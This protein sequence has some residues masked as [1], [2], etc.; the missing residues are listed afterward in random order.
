[1]TST[2]LAGEEDIAADWVVDSDGNLRFEYGDFEAG[3]GFADYSGTS[4]AAPHVTG[5]LGLLF[6]RFP[7]LTGAQ[8]RDVMLT[9]AR[10][11]GEEGVDEIYGWGLL[12]LAAAIE[13]PRQLRVDTV[14]EM[15]LAAG[16]HRTW[17]GDAWDDWTNDIGGPGRLVKSGAGWLRLSG[18]NSFAGATVDQGIL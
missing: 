3:Y 15:N 16:G 2:V 1:I 17:E 8:V 4:M 6:E 5:A 18:D 14:V 7:Y 13:G 11:I 12:D 9:T 10:D